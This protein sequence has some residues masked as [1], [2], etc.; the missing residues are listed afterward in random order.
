[1]KEL[2][3]SKANNGDLRSHMVSQE[4]SVRN[5]WYEDL[6]QTLSKS[7]G[8]KFR[9]GE[10]AH[11]QNRYF[12]P[13]MQGIRNALRLLDEIEQRDIMALSIWFKFK[14]GRFYFRRCHAIEDYHAILNYFLFRKGEAKQEDKLVRGLDGT[15]LFTAPTEVADFME[16]LTKEVVGGE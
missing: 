4:P 6:F 5:G 10:K 8:F 3:Y 1:M 16:S 14:S 2:S 11:I 12:R 13:T 7:K 9:W 15:P